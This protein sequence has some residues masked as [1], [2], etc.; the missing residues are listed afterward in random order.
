LEALAVLG[1]VDRVGRRAEDRHLG[2]FQGSRQVERR[3]PTELHD[4][5]EEIP[6]LLFDAHDFDDILGG[7][8][9]EI[10]PVGGVVIG[11]DGFG[12]AI[13]HDRLDAGLAQAVGGMDAAIVE[14][15]ALADPVGPAAQ[16]DDLLAV[17][18]IGLAFRRLDAVALVAG[19]HIRRQRGELGGTGIDA[20]VDGM[21]T[22]PMPQR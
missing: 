21:K 5:A 22:E 1:E 15:D 8:R 13:D 7:Q 10:E 2:P 17:A 18:R 4:D 14:L 9:L 11:R 20:L 3:L 19:I 12:V 6:A 16:N